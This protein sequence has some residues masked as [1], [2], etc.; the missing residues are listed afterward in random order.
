MAGDDTAYDTRPDGAE[1]ESLRGFW[2]KIGRVAGQVPF[3]E[4]AVAAYY[5]ATDPLT[6]S[7]VKGILVGA[8]VYF[9]LPADLIPDFLAGLGYT[10]DATV[11]MTALS[12]VGSQLRTSHRNAARSFLGKP[13]LATGPDAP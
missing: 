8:L 7:T 4:D 3:V 1:P 6:P 9:V 2:G 12:A 5:C 11:L 13:P 10:D